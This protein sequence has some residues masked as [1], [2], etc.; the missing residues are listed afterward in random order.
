MIKK[1]TLILTALL[2]AAPAVAQEE[3]RLLSLEDVL[4]ET[5]GT[6]EVIALAK[7][8]L[9]SSELLRRL[10]WSAVI[11]QA[12]FSGSVI[13]NDRAQE[14]KFDIPGM[15]LPEDASSG[16][17]ITPLYDWNTS[18]TVSQPLFV[19]FRDWKTLKQTGL[20]I[21]LSEDQLDQAKRDLLFQVSAGYAR[22]LKAQ[23][24]LEISRESLELVKRQLAQ[25]Q[26]LFNAG[27]TIRTSV[28][29]AE[30]GVAQAEL[31]V[32]AAETELAKA[33]ED[34]A[35][36]TGIHPPYRL[37]S[38]D[39]PSLPSEKIESLVG[40]GL[41]RRAEM[42]ALDKQLE[43]GQLEIDKIFGEKLPTVFLNFNYTKQR[44]Q[45]PASSFYRFILNVSVP[46]FDG[47]MSTVNKA[48][49][50]VAH[51]RIQLQQQLLAK[52]IRAEITQA[53]LDYT[54]VNKAL[55]SARK[56]VELARRAYEDI[57]RFYRVGE[58]TDLDV[59]D[60]RQRL[61]EAEKTLSNLSTDEILSL[62]NLRRQLGLLVV[63]ILEG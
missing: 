35:V 54:S 28:L 47:G 34:L 58:V 63:D 8:N 41:E 31:G 50:E 9:K 12:S 60:A 30:A 18:F 61:I 52:Q 26:V 3:G 42:R 1:L 5:L 49:A 44:S 24:N 13:R 20:N 11:P 4:R 15:D 19:G 22:V 25:A 33:R 62:F 46:V 14:I 16:F 29:R 56:Q 23:R 32:I 17:V 36:L 43:I 27:E 6:N 7:E 48:Q 53:Y 38:L 39:E 59:Q 40:F 51:R 55:L 21:G 2:F 37:R 57:E 10:A 45:F